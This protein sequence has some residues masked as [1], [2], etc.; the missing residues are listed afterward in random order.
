MKI[1]APFFTSFRTKITLIIVLAMLFSGALSNYL[2]YEYSSKF[3]FNQLRN[4]LITIARMAALQVNAVTVLGVPLDKAGAKSDEYRL[5][6]ERFSRIREAAPSINYIYIMRRT[7]KDGIFKFVIDV[8]AGHRAGKAA[9]AS[10]GDEYD[11]SRFPEM[12][13]GFE[14]SSA[15][16]RIDAD[17]WGASLSAYTP[18]RD[19]S[20]ESVALLGVDM[21]ADD[22]YRLQT[23]VR[24]RAIFVLALG[25]IL[26]VALGLIV[27]GTVTGPLQSLVEGTRHVAM[28]NLRYHVKVKGSDEFSEL[29]KSFNKMSSDLRTHIKRLNQTTAEKERL[30]K[31]LEIAHGI[32][33]SFLPESA[34]VIKGFDLAATTVP[35]RVVGGDFYDFIPVDEERVG[36]VMA[37]VSGKGVP[38]ALFMALSRT[39][40]RASAM[41][42]HTVTDVLQKANKLIFEESRSNMFVTLFYAL[43]DPKAMSL[44]YANAGHNP[45]LLL[46]EDTRDIVMLKA[47][48]V[49][50]GMLEDLAMTDKTIELKKGDVV[51]LYT[52]GVTEAVNRKKEQFETD[53]LSAIVRENTGM[54]SEDI[55]KKIQEEVA[56]F[57][58]DQP[59]FDDITLMVLKV[60]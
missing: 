42:R 27:S 29:A 11:G 28:G 12:V 47:Q 58:G 48:G 19:G 46:R 49:P 45:P 52:D 15:D 22:V 10:P 20:G 21:A 14:E 36:L 60:V 51:A 1:R 54:H 24:K 4:R 34:P 41:G 56:A 2:I 32:Q 26:S 57:V 13:E 43:L 25:L 18:I 31:E 59:Q 44:R 55:I 39:V 8:K 3:Q 33:Q 38:A 50:L 40:V 7:D 16:K 6:L 5:L 37:D 35:A 9:T 53:R 23:E 30:L 17:E